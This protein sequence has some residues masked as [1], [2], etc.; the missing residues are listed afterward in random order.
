MSEKK[1]TN[2]A[3]TNAK[4]YVVTWTVIMPGLRLRRQRTERNLTNTCITAHEMGG[5]WGWSL[6]KPKINGKP[7][8]YQSRI[9]IRPKERSC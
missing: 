9:N 3:I 4:K 1:I 8:E 2:G 7:Y 5:T 6:A